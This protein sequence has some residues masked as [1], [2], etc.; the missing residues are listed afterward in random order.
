MAPEAPASRASTPAVAGVDEAGRGPLAGPVVVAAVVLGADHGLARL[1]D[2][3]RLTEAVREALFDPI[4]QIALAWHIETVPVVEIE[5]YNILQATLRGMQRAVRALDPAPVQVL[6]DGNRTP[7]LHL[8]CRAIVGGDGIE[9][10]ISAASILA[11][12][13]R[14]RLMVALEDRYPGYGFARHKGYPTPHHL[15]QL[16]HLGPCPEHR[17]TFAPV[18]RLLEPE[19]FD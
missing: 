2:S 9:A 5:E 13:H 15:E 17:R 6:V 12:V 10:C 1:D 16:A 14:D 4:R 18:R 11:K 3:K 7:D 19:L 8:P